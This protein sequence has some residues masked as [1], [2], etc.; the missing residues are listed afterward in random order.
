MTVSMDPQTKDL[1]ANADANRQACFETLKSSLSQ[2]K[3]EFAPAS[4]RFLAASSVYQGWYLLSVFLLKR[5]TEV[6]YVNPNRRQI[7]DFES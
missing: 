3:K 7:Q 4:M 5:G 1:L 2:S 6:F